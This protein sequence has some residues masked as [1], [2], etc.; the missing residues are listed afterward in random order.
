MAPFCLFAS[1]KVVLFVEP[2]K[3]FLQKMRLFRKIAVPLHCQN[4]AAILIKG[5]KMAIGM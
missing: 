4:E 1:A 5:F 3:F 2:N